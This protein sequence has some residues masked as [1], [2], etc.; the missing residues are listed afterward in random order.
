ME[1]LGQ[2][3]RR[4]HGLRRIGG[5]CR[6]LNLAKLYGLPGPRNDVGASPAI[7]AALHCDRAGGKAG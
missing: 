5:N 2:R 1:P 7:D 6:E 4:A 3:S